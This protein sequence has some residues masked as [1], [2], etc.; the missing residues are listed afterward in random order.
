MKIGRNGQ[1]LDFAIS[2][3]PAPHVSFLHTSV[4]VVKTGATLGLVHIHGLPTD[5]RRKQ[6]S[7]PRLCVADAVEPPSTS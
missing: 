5:C 2:H 6:A 4:D 1:V 7:A 3:V